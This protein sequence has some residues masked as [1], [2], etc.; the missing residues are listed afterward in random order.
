MFPILSFECLSF[1][2]CCFRYL[3]EFRFVELVILFIV[4]G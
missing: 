3:I 1:I 2:R 4:C